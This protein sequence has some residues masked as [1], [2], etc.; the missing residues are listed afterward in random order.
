[1]PRRLV[2]NSTAAALDKV[3]EDWP[4]V[5]YVTQ[6]IY[7]G[8]P[9]DQ[10]DYVSILAVLV[11]T[12][13]RGTVS[14]SSASTLDQPVIQVAFL[15]DAKDQELALAAIR[16]TR[17]MFAHPSLAPVLIGAEAIPGNGTATDAQLLNYIQS[18]A[19]TLWHASSTCKMGKRNDTMAVVDSEGKVFGVDKLR[20][21]DLSAVPFLPPGH[22]SATIY[23]LAEKISAVMLQSE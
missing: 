11:N 13:S 15:T 7:P 23:A 17:E 14:I 18:S 10:G 2:S 22:P 1:M 9:P 12:F 20:V 5:E 8:I 16:R 4:D 19:R 21:V 6:S 3:P